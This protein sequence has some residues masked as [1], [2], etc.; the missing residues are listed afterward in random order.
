MLFEN[1]AQAGQLLASR[2]AGY[3]LRPDT[4]ILALP[5]G[6]VPVAF[7]VARRLRA[8]MDVFVVRKLGVPG[9][10]EL[11]MGA[12]A[13]GGIRVL[14]YDVLNSLEIPS[15]TIEAVA[16]RET[17]ELERREQ[18]YRSG[19]S[20]LAIEGRIV[21]LVDDGLA[22]G[23]TMRAAALA[24]RR[25]G[26]Q[27]IVVAVPVAP[28][29]V[30]AELKREVDEVVCGETPEPFHAVGSWYRDFTQVTDNEVRELLER[31]VSLNQDS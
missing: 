7:E 27:K 18:L 1:R 14:N 25:H 15:Q 19:R 31:A 6:G 13:S 5:R 2:L 10:S 22:T 29:S 20:L 23:S 30:C 26:P 9:H 11:A 12:V 24:L 17:L 21:I 8:N 4:A 28:P 16:R 3:A